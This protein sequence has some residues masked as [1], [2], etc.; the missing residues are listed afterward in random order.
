MRGPAASCS[1]QVAGIVD[2]QA[3]NWAH[4]SASGYYHSFSVCTLTH[5]QV[6]GRRLAGREGTQPDSRHSNWLLSNSTG[7]CHRS[8][9]RTALVLALLTLALLTLALLT[10]ALPSLLLYPPDPRTTPFT[11]LVSSQICRKATIKKLAIDAKAGPAANETKRVCSL[12][13]RTSVK[14]TPPRPDG[15]S[16]RGRGE[17]CSGGKFGLRE[18]LKVRGGEAGANR[19]CARTSDR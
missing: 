5:M 19:P 16:R 13:R 9:P 4:H 18:L 3:L 1:C 7:T 15:T 2:V 8:S 17:E 14:K 6:T 11:Q 12:R 10:L